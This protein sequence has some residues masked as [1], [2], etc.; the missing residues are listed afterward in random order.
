MTAIAVIAA[1]EIREGIRN[2]WVAAATAI[3]AALAVSDRKSV[4]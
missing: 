4:A 3:L 1:R 2:K